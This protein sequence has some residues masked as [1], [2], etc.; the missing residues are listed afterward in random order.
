MIENDIRAG[1]VTLDILKIARDPKSALVDLVEKVE[2]K[3]RQK[4]ESFDESELDER[5]KE[6]D[7]EEGGAFL[8]KIKDGLS[9]GG[10]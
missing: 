5:G 3:P 8:E 4:L 6:D 1:A 2:K 9:V 7:G 10:N